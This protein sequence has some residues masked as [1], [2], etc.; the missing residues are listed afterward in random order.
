MLGSTGCLRP[1]QHSCC[2]RFFTRYTN[3]NKPAG[4]INGRQNSMADR[5]WKQLPTWIQFVLLC[6]LL[7]GVVI[8]E[9]IHAIV[10]LLEG[11]ESV[12]F[13]WNRAEI[14]FTWQNKTGHWT[15]IAPTIVAVAIIPGVVYNITESGLLSVVYEVIQWMLI[16]HPSPTDLNQ[17]INSY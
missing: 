9:Y 2:I 1:L 14:E 15:W 11:A 7:P 8:H 4:S 5:Y 10:G 16:A 12:Q 6:L 13:D 3:S 17:F